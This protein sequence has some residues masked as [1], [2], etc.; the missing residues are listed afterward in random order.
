MLDEYIVGDVSRVSP[1]AP[2]PVVA[3]AET[4]HRPGGAANVARNLRALGASV[5]LGAVVG[6]DVAGVSLT[7][8][9]REAGIL[10]EALSAVPGRVTPRKL[11]VLSQHQQLLRLDWERVEPVDPAVS[12][13]LLARWDASAPP[14]VVVLS[15]YAKG[16]CTPELVRALIDRAR[17]MGVPTVVGPKRRDLSVYRGASVLVPNLRELEV[18]AGRSL[19]ADDVLP[20]ARQLLAEAEVGAIVVTLGASGMLAVPRDGDAVRVPAHRHE[21]YD[22]TGAGDTV[23]ATLAL[24]F[25]AGADLASAARMA[26][27]AAGVAV[28]RIGTAAVRLDELLPALDLEPADRVLDSPEA[29]DA[30]L[31]W[32]RLQ[33]RRVAFTNGCFDLLHAGHVSLLHAARARG[34]ALLVGLNSD[35]SVARLKGAGRP[36]VPWRER[37]AVLAGLGCVDGVVGFDDDTPLSLI[38]AVRPDVLVKGADYTLDRVVGRAEVEAAGGEVVLVPMLPGASTTSTLARARASP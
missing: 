4:F 37:A 14:D 33:G 27:A 1:E 38:R 25:A 23:L 8:A 10:L 30:W 31:T 20:A 12:L 34:D 5:R 35:A 24:A 18:A 6:D 26:S 19:G 16:F 28:G 32:R 11:R 22:V 3:V 29:L 7:D 17:A 13:A 2:V 36:V 9:C 15:D 21:V